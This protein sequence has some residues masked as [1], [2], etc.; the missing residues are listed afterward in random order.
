MSTLLPPEPSCSGN[1]KGAPA[2][3]E[4]PSENMS[5]LQA[6]PIQNSP[7]RP[8]LQARLAVHFGI[9]AACAPTERLAAARSFTASQYRR[10]AAGGGGGA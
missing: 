10:R 2:F 9:E 3:A 6:R 7:T 4:T 1:R 5:A 8:S